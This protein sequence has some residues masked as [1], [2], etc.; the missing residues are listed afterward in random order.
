[1][2]RFLAGIA[3]SLVPQLV[4]AQETVYSL[5]PDS[6]QARVAPV[7]RA[8]QLVKAGIGLPLFR[9]S[10][11]SPPFKTL[12]LD[13]TLERKIASGLA[14]VVG[15]ETQYSFSQYA[16]LYTVELPIGLRYYFSV[17][18]K[19]KQRNDPHGFFS[20]YVSLQTHNALF[21]SLFYDTPNPNVQRYH[22][23]Q[24]LDHDTNVGKYDE[25]FNMMQHAYFQIG[26]QFKLSGNAYLDINAALPIRKLVY[27]KSDYTLATPAYIN[28]KYGI[29]WPK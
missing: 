28:I 19:M 2:F 15:L 11:V 6:T 7:S 20:Y 10:S 25:A 13:V 29:A 24:I 21:S 8:R 1:M 14:V 5:I 22:R 17:G 27:T 4:Q 3:L 23:G 18:K 12:G 26:S 9:Q 16:Q